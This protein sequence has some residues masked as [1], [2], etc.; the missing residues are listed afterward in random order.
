MIQQFCPSLN[1]EVISYA[2]P[3]DGKQPKMFG[4]NFLIIFTIF[5]LLA[6]YIRYILSSDNNNNNN[7]K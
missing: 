6:L 5:N 2:C 4:L 7:N 3:D 1:K